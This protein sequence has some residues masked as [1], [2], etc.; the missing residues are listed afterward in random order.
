MELG[1]FLSY[2]VNSD[3]QIDDVYDRTFEYGIAA[4]QSGFGHLWFP[5]HHLVQFLPAPS[6]LLAAVAIGQRVKCRVGT[7]VVVLPY[8][9]SLQLA[10]EIAAADQLLGGRFDL[11]VAR[12]AYRYEFDKFGLDFRESRQHFI[13]MLDS[14][15][16]IWANPESATTFRGSFVDFEE[17]HVWPHPKQSPN[18][19]IWIG[20]QTAPAVEDAAARGYNVF[21]GLFLWDSDHA[22]S[23]ADAFHRGRSK[24]PQGTSPKLGMSRYGFAV[25]DPTETDARLQD[26]RDGWR[27]HRQLHDYTQNADP[28]GVVVPK[29]GENEPT[30]DEMRENVMIGTADQIRPKMEFYQSL[31]VD[32]LTINGCFG[33]PHEDTLRSIKLLGDLGA[34]LSEGSRV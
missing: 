16:A 6:A 24:A 25:S 2:Q 33:A 10:G 18:P 7:A 22:S 15:R 12:G 31:G 9:Q 19:P 4:D 3:A 1:L 13:E 26:M 5:E 17:A 23:I 29:V 11:G 8:H 32:V 21:H 20:A 30:L 28:R 14:M 27:I 34:K